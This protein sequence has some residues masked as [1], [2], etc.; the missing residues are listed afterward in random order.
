MQVKII[1]E[2]GYE[3]A[4]LGMSLSRN[5]PPENMVK[6]AN[7][8]HNKDGGHNKFLEQI[9]VWIDIT[10]PRFFWQQLATYRV[11]NSWQSES[12]MYTITKKPLDQTN[13]EY[14]IDEC[15]LQHLNDLITKKDLEAVKNVLPEGFLQRR[16]MSTNYKALRNIVVQRRHHKLQ[17]WHYFVNE[18]LGG[19]EH[20]ELID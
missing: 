1:G 8:L 18:V 3:F 12:T 20:P 19:L 15:V 17:E 5:Q 11:G 16:I 13:F 14:P 7:N 4:L 10:A 9:A 2:Y 6:V